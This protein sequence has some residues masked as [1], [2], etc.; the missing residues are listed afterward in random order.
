[1]SNLT[2]ALIAAKLMGNGGS[3]GGSGSGGG[4]YIE[5]TKGTPTL[6]LT[7]KQ[8]ANAITGGNSV[9]LGVPAED[10]VGATLLYSCIGFMSETGNYMAIFAGILGLAPGSRYLQ[11]DVLIFSASS[12]DDYLALTA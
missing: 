7:Y 1:M 3:G 8:V 10:Q 11:G 4:L 12:E 2:D 5:Y 6:N 9:K